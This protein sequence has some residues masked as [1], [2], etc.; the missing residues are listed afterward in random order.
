MGIK[1]LNKFLLQKCSNKSIQK[2]HLSYFENKTL[3]I[4]AS[5]YLYKF[6]SDDAL[7]ENTFLFISILRKYNITPVF[8]FDGKPPVEKHKLLLQRKKNKKDAE[9]QYNE[10]K[11]TSTECDK[12]ELEKL[13]KQFLKIS[14]QQ[15]NEVKQLLQ[16]YGIQYYVSP[17]EA[18]PLCVYFVKT[19]QS[20][21]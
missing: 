12:Y 4:D 5:I 11:E 8:I 18:D 13:K 15:I 2:H 14:P 20:W 7:I 3:V 21:A 6:L 19:N 1:H 16:L 9:R 17:T 10:L